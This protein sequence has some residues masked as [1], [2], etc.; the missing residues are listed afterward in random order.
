MVVWDRPR[1]KPWRPEN[2]RNPHREDGAPSEQPD[3][4]C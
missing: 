2:W 3:W 4:V 1:G